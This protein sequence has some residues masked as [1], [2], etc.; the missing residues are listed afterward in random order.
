MSENFKMPLLQEEKQLDKKELLEY[1]KN[2]R[3][4][5]KNLPLD[6]NNIRIKELIHPILLKIV[7]VIFDNKITVFNAENLPDKDEVCIYAFNHSNGHDFP[8]AASVVKN[9]FYILADYTMKN[10]LKVNIA[11]K[12]NGVVY[13]DRKSKLNRQKAKE[14]LFQLLSNGKS[15][16]V[17]PEATWNLSPNLMMLPLNWGIIELAR[18]CDVPII[19]G[20]INY[21]NDQAYVNI[22][23][24]MRVD[25]IDDKTTKIEELTD[26]L[27]TLKWEMMEKFSVDKRENLQDNYYD[28]FIEKELSTYPKLDFEYENSVILKKQPTPDDVF[29][30]IKKLKITKNNAF[31]FN[32]NYG[33]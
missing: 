9:H 12:S 31:L 14:R 18:V 29:E 11:N 22:G 13:V 33:K 5:Y 21:S 32:R 23:K 6:K 10:D 30:P 20:I 4:Y 27:S 2:L 3:N 7:R 1:Y 8:V 19:P 15:I 26:S 24:P 16:F 25:V 17:F 28:L